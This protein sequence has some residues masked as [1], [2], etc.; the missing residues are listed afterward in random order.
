MSKGLL[1][2]QPNTC[3]WG[4]QICC[5]PRAGFFFIDKG[6]DERVYHAVTGLC[7]EFKNSFNLNYEI[8]HGTPAQP[9]FVIQINK[10]KAYQKQ[11]YALNANSETIVINAHSNCG[12][13]F[14]VQTLKQLIRST[15]NKFNSVKI[16]DAPAISE[17]GYMLDISR[18][19]VPSLDTLKRIINQLSELKY[20]Q[21]QLY[22]EHTYAFTA[23]EKVWRGSSAYNST[24]I[25]E[26]KKY[27]KLNNISLVPNLNSFGHL[28]RWLKHEDYKELAECPK[29]F[30]TSW[31]EYRKVGSVIKPNSKSLTFLNGLYDEMLPNFDSP[32]FNVGCD[33]TWELGQGYS[34]KA[35]AEKGRVR[36]YLDFLLNIQKLVQK[37]NK[38]MMFWGDIILDRPELIKE[39]PKDIIALEWGYE[40]KH[41]FNKDCASFSKSGIPFY[42]CPGTSAWKT[43]TGKTKNMSGNLINAARNGTKYAAQGFL[44]TDWGDQGHHQTLPVSYPGIFMAGC[45]SW[46]VPKNK[47]IDWATAMDTHLFNNPRAKMGKW[48]LDFGQVHEHISQPVFNSSFFHH[49]FFIR[50]HDVNKLAQI[51]AAEMKKC[52][53]DFKKLKEELKQVT[54]KSDDAALLKDELSFSLYM[55]T[56]AALRG[57]AISE[58]KNPSGA[59]LKKRI[60]RTADWHKRQWLKRNRPGGLKES[61]AHIKKEL[62]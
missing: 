6:F 2:P 31:G 28:Q 17:R 42:V 12:A 58:G 36:V 3:R 1:A 8:C 50:N 9:G 56:T 38:K 35:C 21:L 25:L 41:P 18:C 11:A 26:I 27:A 60:S 33:E 22:T 48:L 24:D 57:L 10:N 62:S 23:H 61:L 14:A 46:G 59:T 53:R 19:K 32:Y 44:L 39:L 15:E 49:Q 37:Q 7:A 34:K 16:E 55:A 4:K 5:L 54:P 20:N 29:G 51:P 40:A 52:L 47:N 43:L 13:F 30:H 45:L